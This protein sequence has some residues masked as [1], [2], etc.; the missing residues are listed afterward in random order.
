MTVTSPIGN[1]SQAAA[2]YNRTALQQG[3]GGIEARAPADSDGFAEALRDAA[4]GVVGALKAGETET[5]KAAA[6]QAD[7]NDVVMAVSQAEITLETVVA[8]RDRV[9]KAYQD[10]INMPI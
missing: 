2:A 1:F 8:L 9:I 10:I 4:E 6:G 5:M 3:A 7:I